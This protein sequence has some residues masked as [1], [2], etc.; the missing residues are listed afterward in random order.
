MR[1]RVNK[2]R[3]VDGRSRGLF[4]LIVLAPT[5]RVDRQD[6]PADVRGLSITRKMH[7]KRCRRVLALHESIFTWG[8]EN[9]KKGSRCTPPERPCRRPGI[10]AFSR[11]PY[12]AVGLQRTLF[13]KRAEHRRA[14]VGGVSCCAG[15]SHPTLSGEQIRCRKRRSGISLYV[16]T[17]PHA[18]V[19]RRQR[20]RRVHQGDRAH[21]FPA[22][23]DHAVFRQQRN[24]LAE[25]VLNKR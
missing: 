23:S 17:E 12:A 11:F 14:V 10:S 19:R 7:G 21:G 13:R 4:V 24:P 15:N 8:T 5:A 3:R 20:Q 2:G 9:R 18:Y 22:G 6:V 25:R 16:P 1:G